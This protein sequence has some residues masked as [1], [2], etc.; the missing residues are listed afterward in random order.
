M[1]ISILGVLRERNFVM[2]ILGGLRKWEIKIM[3]HIKQKKNKNK[4]IQ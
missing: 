2:Q 4:T 3:G 1:K